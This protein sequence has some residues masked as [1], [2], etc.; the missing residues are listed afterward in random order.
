MR[1]KY[2]SVPS[3]M[4]QLFM[5]MSGG[6]DWGDAYELLGALDPM[7][8]VMFFVYIFFMV[9]AVVNVVTGIF[10]DTAIQSSLCDREV[11]MSE[12]LA[13]KEDQMQKL[14]ELFMEMDE[15]N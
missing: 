13:D 6:M 8:R 4:M 3:A 9:F 11:V 5:A 2:G 15:D 14:Q 12:L 7:Y 10:V 1:D